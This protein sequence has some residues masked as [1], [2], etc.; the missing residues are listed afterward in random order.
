M[1]NKKGSRVAASRVDFGLLEVVVTDADLGFGRIVALYY[2]SS[3]LYQIH[4]IF[5]TSISEATMRPS[6]TQTVRTAAGSRATKPAHSTRC[7]PT[8]Q[9]SASGAGG[10]T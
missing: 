10:G 4:N 9:P 6:P 3:T 5:G 8:Q 2:R 1:P 7:G